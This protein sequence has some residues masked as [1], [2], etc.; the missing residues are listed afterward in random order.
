MAASAPVALGLGGLAAVLVISGIQ[1]RSLGEVLKG[2][3]THK[4]D[5][6]PEGS[7]GSSPNEAPVVGQTDA[8]SRTRILAAAAGQLGV[9]Y[10]WGGEVENKG[11]D[12]SGLTQW[13]YGQGGVKIPRTAQEQYNYMKHTK[14]PIPADLVFFG[15]GPSNVSHVGILVGP[16]LMEDAEH[17]G[18]RIRYTP[19]TPAIGAKWGSDKLIGYGTA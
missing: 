16:G 8:G 9:P 15:S 10:K 13:A 17:T 7:T 6:G 12:C 19:F 1:D 4:T 5:S 11:F 3:I 2:S 18:T 14:T